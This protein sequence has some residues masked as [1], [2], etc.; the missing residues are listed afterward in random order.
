MKIIGNFT[1]CFIHEQGINELAFLQTANE[2]IGFFRPALAFSGLFSCGRQTA[3]EPLRQGEP[4][5]GRLDTPLA[6]LSTALRESHIAMARKRM[7]RSQ[8][9]QPATSWIFSKTSELGTGVADVW[10]GPVRKKLKTA[11]QFTVRVANCVV[12]VVMAVGF[13]EMCAGFKR[14]VYRIAVVHAKSFK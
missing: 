10:P 12:N 1:S 13:G 5:A 8:G 9:K 6:N 11:G 14:R 2:P 4:R 7:R 3:N